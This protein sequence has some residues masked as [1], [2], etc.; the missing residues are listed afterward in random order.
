M[1]L[2]NQYCY[3]YDDDL[4]I[5]TDREGFRRRV[6]TGDGL[7][8]CFWRIAG[9]ATG[10]FL[11]R[12]EDHEQLGIIVRGKLDFRIND[13]PDSEE[14]VVLGEGEAYI[15][16]KGVWHGDSVFIGDDEYGECWILDV[17]TPPRDDL[18]AS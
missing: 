4:F 12:H 18:L 17:F 10:S 5:D 15:A 3:F 8:L 14:R 1:N 9:G 6:I 2:T 11:H 13:D 7:Q 16:P